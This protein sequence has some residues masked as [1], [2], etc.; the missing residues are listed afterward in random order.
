MMLMICCPERHNASQNTS[1]A[2]RGQGQAGDAR[3]E[4]RQCE[5]KAGQQCVQGGY[6]KERVPCLLCL[7]TGSGQHQQ[8]GK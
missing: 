8:G 6:T 3:R 5:W 1:E 4:K 2:A 7:R